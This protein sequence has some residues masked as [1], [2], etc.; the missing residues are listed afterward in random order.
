[1][2]RMVSYLPYSSYAFV[3]PRTTIFTM[4]F[5]MYM[6]PC[7]PVPLVGI[8]GNVLPRT[9]ILSVETTLHTPPRPSVH[10]LL[11]PSFLVLPCVC[12]SVYT[13]PIASVHV[14]LRASVLAVSVL[15]VC[16]SFC[17]TEL[18]ASRAGGL[19]PH[20]RGDQPAAMHIWCAALRRPI[21]VYLPPGG[22][23]LR[24][25]PQKML[26]AAGQWNT[27]QP[28]WIIMISGGALFHPV[29]PPSGQGTPSLGPGPPCS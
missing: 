4:E 15:H 2:S 21:L 22:G 10:M 7:M 20:E 16:L 17:P 29:Q 6:N 27:G 9:P 25:S 8:Y 11:Q 14:P 5:S 13:L 18:T 28:G 26:I 19:P 24:G 12:M 1:M 3:L 23:P